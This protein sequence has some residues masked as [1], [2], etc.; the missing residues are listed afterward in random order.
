MKQKLNQAQGV[1]LERITQKLQK[2][3]Q[4]AEAEVKKEDDIEE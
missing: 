2:Q 4:V 3:K 1:L